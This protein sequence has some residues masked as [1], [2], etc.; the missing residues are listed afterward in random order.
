MLAAPAA[1]QSQAD[2]VDV[3]VLSLNDFHGAFVQNPFQN[4]PGGASVI[5][6]LDSL[7]GVY[8]YHLTVSAGDNFGGSYFYTATNGQLM[9]VFLREAGIR[10]SAVGNHEFDDGQEALADKWSAAPLRSEG[11]DVKYLCANVLDSL[12]NRPAYMEPYTVEQVRLSPTKTVRVALVSM[13]AS[14]AQEQISARRIVGMKFRGD[15]TRVLSE[16]QGQPDFRQV[17]EAEVR[18]LLLH[19][20]ANTVDGRPVWN[21]KNTDELARINTPL[22]QAFLVGHSHDA[23]CGHINES[24]KPVTQGYWHG[25]Y[26]SM[27]RFRVDTVRM[28]VVEVIPEI[29]PVR[30]RRN[31]ELSAHARRFQ[32]LVDSL[33]A[34]TRTKAGAALGE[35][36]AYVSQDLAHDRAD[37]YRVSP[38][39]TLVC[40][41]YAAAY[42]QV[43]SDPMV[44]GMSHFGSVR[45]GFTKGD[46]TVLD[47]GE[48][49][50]FQNA[51][52]AYRFTGEELLRLLTVGRRNQRYGWL[53]YS[54]L[55]VEYSA[56]GEALRATFVSPDGQRQP[57]TATDTLTAVVDEYIAGG[58]DGFQGIF[59][60]DRRIDVTLPA[61]TDCFINYL[62][63]RKTI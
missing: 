42:R 32:A 9:P 44:V 53:Q 24:R 47:V 27:M 29:V 21:D 59:F 45:G 46:I 2:I 30:A 54:N 3:A 25:C 6:T 35:H 36:V 37:R 20:G 40:E 41:G 38:V 60:P 58:G 1:A 17:E 28:Q 16:L 22:Y 61:A 5:Q 56:D 7:R 43:K 23:V 12:G 26:I 19:I 10:I 52:R 33:L 34:C 57:L 49:L 14:S 31:D 8:P 4:I 13:L 15:Y 51:M 39:A 48:V 50:P 62:R 63:A 18:A 55:D 11:W